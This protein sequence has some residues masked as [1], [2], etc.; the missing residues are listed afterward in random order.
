MHSLRQFINELKRRNDLLVI[1]KRVN[2]DQEI[3]EIHRRFVAKQGPALLFTNVIGSSFPVVTNLYGTIDRVNLAFGIDKSS[4]IE[5]IVKK[6]EEIV[7]D[8]LKASKIG[9]EGKK[10]A[11]KY[12]DSKHYLNHM[13]NYLRLD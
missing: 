5:D 4:Q 7:I 9:F 3:A 2:P 10:T 8:P 6:M 1:D 11:L 13:L 12:F